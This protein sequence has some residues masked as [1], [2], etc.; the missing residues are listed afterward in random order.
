MEAESEMQIEDNKRFGHSLDVEEL[1]V[2]QQRK[3]IN[4]PSTPLKQT[5]LPPL[6]Q[7]DLPA[8]SYTKKRAS[9]YYR[10]IKDF[11][12]IRENTNSFA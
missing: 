12:G 6:K 5:D 10:R 7:D 3:L 1:K 11:G 9:L 8:S 4:F 2:E